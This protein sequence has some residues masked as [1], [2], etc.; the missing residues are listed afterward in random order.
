MTF[1]LVNICR[2][3]MEV[4]VI[5]DEVQNWMIYNTHMCHHIW[6]ECDS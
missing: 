6:R 2:D 3:T 4:L 5:A 1:Q